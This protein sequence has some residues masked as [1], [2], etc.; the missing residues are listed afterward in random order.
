M[1]QIRASVSYVV[2][3]TFALVAAGSLLAYSY[4]QH[5]ATWES[6][7]DVIVDQRG[8]GSINDADGGLTATLDGILNYYSWNHTP[9]GTVFSAHSGDV[10]AYIGVDGTPTLSFDD[11]NS[12]CTGNCLASTR[13]AYQT[14]TGVTY[15]Y[16]AD[17][18]T[19]TNYSWTSFDEDPDSATCS[20]EFYIESIQVHEVGHLLGL[21]HSTVSGATMKSSTS[22]CKPGPATIES[23]DSQ[24][25]REL[26]TGNPN[27]QSGGIPCSSDSDCCDGSC[28]RVSMPWGITYKLC[29]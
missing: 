19:N 12:R 22:A 26:Y 5:G 7:P 29:Q 23:D 1:R 17:I 20:G 11:P 2:V 4:N 28:D 16:D 21:G 18:V 15:I 24:G 10:S 27:C 6:T 9:L 13:R 8:L 25:L 14:I 3:L